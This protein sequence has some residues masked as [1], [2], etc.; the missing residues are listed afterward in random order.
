MQNGDF[1]RISY[2]G[3]LESGEIFDLTDAEKA[4]AAGIFN[5]NAR[6]GPVPVIIGENF[7]LPELEKGLLGMEVG[8]KKEFTIPP[9]AAFGA[10]DPALVRTVPARAFG[11]QLPQ[12]GQIVQLRTDRGILRGRVQSITA[13]R[14]RIDFNHPLAGKTLKYEVEI[15]EKI[16]KDEGKISAIL[17]YFELEPKF[18]IKQN[19]LEITAPVPQQIKK[20]IS[21]LILKYISG[22]ERVE[23]VDRFEKQK[24]E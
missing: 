22:I 19:V 23:F 18:E 17:E 3:R 15:I 12:Q 20:R 8:Q 9:E 16:E 24:P 14:V 21:D 6:Y 4:K 11:S 5:P 13:G 2:I 10:R 7:I 1:V